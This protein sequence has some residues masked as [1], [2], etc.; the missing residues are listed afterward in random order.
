MITLK[1]I[2]IWKSCAQVIHVTC[3][4]FQRSRSLA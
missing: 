1:T 4:S 2:C 3:D